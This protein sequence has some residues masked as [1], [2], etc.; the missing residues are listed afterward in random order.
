MSATLAKSRR[1]LIVI[2]KEDSLRFT[3]GLES[4]IFESCIRSTTSN[5]DKLIFSALDIIS[6][7]V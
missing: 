3:G 6:V 7:R 5:G 4:G 1:V 2:M